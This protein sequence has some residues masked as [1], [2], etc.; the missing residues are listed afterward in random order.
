MGGRHDIPPHRVVAAEFGCDRQADGAREYLEDVVTTLNE[1]G[2]HWAFYSFREDAWDRMDYEVGPGGLGAAYWEAVD[3]GETRTVPGGTTRSG[4]SSR[5]DSRPLGDRGARSSSPGLCV[6][7]MSIVSPQ[8]PQPVRTLVTSV[9]PQAVVPPD[10]RD[11]VSRAASYSA[12][13]GRCSIISGTSGACF[14]CS[15]S[16]AA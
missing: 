14:A 12:S 10:L 5:T 6:R 13:S 15:A 7:E 11:V 3:R 4:G 2:W 1:R 16:Q 9:E 8:P